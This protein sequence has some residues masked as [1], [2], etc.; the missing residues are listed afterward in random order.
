[1]KLVEVAVGILIRADGAA[2]FGERVAGKPYAGWWEFPGGKLEAGESVEQALARELHEELG[3]DVRDSSP[4]V[5]RDFV[6]PH[7]SVRLHFQRV[8]DWRGEPV[9]REGQ[10]F[11]WQR[12]DDISVG[13][14][15]PAAL[16]VIDWLRLPDLIR[17]A[18]L[19][20]PPLELAALRA[21]DLPGRAG[22]AS[23]PGETIRDP[24]TARNPAGTDAAA[25]GL[26]PTVSPMA[27]STTSSAASSTTLSVASPQASWQ[28]TAAA[29]CETADDIER[30]ERLGCGFAI[31]R[32]QDRSVIE[33]LART[34]R[35][36]LF[37]H[38]SAGGPSP[39]FGR[40]RSGWPR[41]IQGLCVDA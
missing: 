29:W 38:E 8:T 36:P 32:E 35:L 5:V 25:A 4:W 24:G 33:A 2:L 30:A 37:I 12:P 3:L 14:M 18:E 22:P 15:L 19:E 10:R 23:H 6:Y 11:V 9:S 13:P 41:G 39:G 27:S 16:P 7:A 20:V 26:T 28:K 1:M 17:L 40:I 31:A 34:T 21:A